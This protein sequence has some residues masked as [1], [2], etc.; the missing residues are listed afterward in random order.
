MAVGLLAL[1]SCSSSGG[2]GTV[3][4][5][6]ETSGGPPGYQPHRLLGKVVF[7]DSKGD[8]VSVR[9]GT[10]GAL[11]VH[12]PSGTYTAVGRSPMVD[13]GSSEMACRTLKPVVVRDGQTQ[14]LIVACQLM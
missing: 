10:S 1:S 7:S 4:G 12:L 6:F 8:R 3:K 14:N 11:L 5:I 2:T 13:S 9:V